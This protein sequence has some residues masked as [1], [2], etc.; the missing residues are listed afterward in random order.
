MRHAADVGGAEACLLAFDQ[1]NAGRASL[2]A[3]N[4]LGSAVGRVIIDHED[5]GLAAGMCEAR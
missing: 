1:M 2:Q 4:L 3:A 5:P